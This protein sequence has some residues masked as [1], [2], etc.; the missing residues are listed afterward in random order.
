MTSFILV[1]GG[2]HGGWCWDHVAPMLRA[3]NHTVLAPDLPGM[4]ADTTPLAKVTLPLTAD[5]IAELIAA[6]TEAP[7]VVGHSLAGLVLSEAAERIPDGI[8]GLVYVT[9]ALL[10][11][12]MSFQDTPGQDAGR[13]GLVLSEDGVAVS[14]VPAFAMET[15]YNTT[16]LDLAR[17]AI[18][19]L[20]PQPVSLIQVPMKLSAERFGRVP[21][22]YIECTEDKAFPISVQRQMH[23]MLPCDPVFTLKT[24]HSPFMSAPEE[25]AGCLF[26]LAKRFL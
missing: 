14:F 5:F 15:F 26:A 18:S 24:D 16:D 23:A 7:I 13:S 21:R 20:T 4:G 3:R 10:P 6:Q 9:A 12:G 8:A 22:A 17:S 25:F 1:H 11:D 19:R 2:M